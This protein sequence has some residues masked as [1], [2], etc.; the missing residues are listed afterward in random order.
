MTRKNW[1]ILLAVFSTGAVVV[2]LAARGALNPDLSGQKVRFR[3][4]A[5]DRGSLTRSVS[6]GGILN[7]VVTV[8]VGSQVSGRIQELLADFNTAVRKDQIIA[9]ID[10]Q[11]F[12]ARVHQAE[13]E[14][15]VAKANVAIQR[16]AVE[17]AEAELQNVRSA[18]RVAEAQ[19]EKA[20]LA[21]ADA[22]RDLQ[23]KE[24][25]YRRNVVSRSQADDARTLHE[26]ALAQHQRA[27]KELAKEF[28]FV[29][30]VENIPAGVK[31]AP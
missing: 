29:Q 16:A 5:V 7:A 26:Q 13:A 23:R 22:L 6:S 27:V 9:R 2:L 11:N 25:L 10:P 15:A 24:E 14:L 30:T 4:L 31:I 12:E 20:R 3:L 1:I 28:E 17:R 19:S 21:V 8:Q 18:K